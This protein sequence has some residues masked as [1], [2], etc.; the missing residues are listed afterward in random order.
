MKRKDWIT[1][2]T[3]GI[4]LGILIVAFQALG[5]FSKTQ[6][7]HAASDAEK[8][9]AKAL[10]SHKNWSALQGEARLVQYDAEGNPHA[11]LISVEVAQP[12]KAT[13]SYKASDYKEKTNKKW[14]SDGEKIYQV[15]DENLSYT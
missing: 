8:A 10:Q 4:I 1:A 9:L 7:V 5:Q 12:L 2:I 3:A 11:D 14:I 6:N 13:V 15:D